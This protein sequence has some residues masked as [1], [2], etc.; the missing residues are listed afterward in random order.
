MR[1]FYV[2]YTLTPLIEYFSEYILASFLK[3]SSSVLTALSDSCRFILFFAVSITH[4]AMFEQWSA[5]RSRFVRRSESTK[6]AA[7]VHS[8][9]WSRVICLERQ[10]FL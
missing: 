5:T 6:P 10:S 1:F 4:P 3:S 2:D 9:C 7:I 8:P